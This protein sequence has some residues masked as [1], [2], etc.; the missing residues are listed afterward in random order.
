MPSIYASEGKTGRL[1]ARHVVAWLL[2][3][4]KAEAPLQRSALGR[5][6]RIEHLKEQSHPP[7]EQIPLLLVSR[8]ITLKHYG[9]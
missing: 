5:T 2:S 4:R 8:E 1:T 3:P 7:T 6:T 9:A